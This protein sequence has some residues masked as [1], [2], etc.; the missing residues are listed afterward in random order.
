MN[1]SQVRLRIELGADSGMGS[2]ALG[3]TTPFSFLLFLFVCL[4]FLVCLL[5]LLL[6]FFAY[7]QISIRFKLSK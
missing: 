4:Y 7:S 1:N 3:E 6:F 2:R 5:L